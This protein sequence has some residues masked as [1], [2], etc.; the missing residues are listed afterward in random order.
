MS[1]PWREFDVANGDGKTARSPT[2][3]PVGRRADGD[4][5]E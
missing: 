5:D 1:N 2:W 3:T 4:A